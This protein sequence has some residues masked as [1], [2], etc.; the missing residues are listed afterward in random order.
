MMRLFGILLLVIAAGVTVGVLP[1]APSW[2][3]VAG[4][5]GLTLVAVAVATLARVPPA[6]GAEPAAPAPASQPGF[7][8]TLLMGWALLFGLTGLGVA[9]G[10]VTGSGPAAVGVQSGLAILLAI[11]FGTRGRKAMVAACLLVLPIALFNVGQG[12]EALRL[13]VG[14]A[15]H[16]ER[17]AAAAAKGPADVYHVA[18]ATPRVDLGGRFVTESATGPRAG[19]TSLT[20]VATAA[21]LLGPSWSA[22][23]PVPMWVVCEDATTEKGGVR[24]A[25][26]K[27]VY[28]RCAKRWSRQGDFASPASDVRSLY[29]RAVEATEKA[30]GL[31]SAASAPAVRWIASPRAAARPQL[32]TLAAIALEILLGWLLFVV[33]RGLRREP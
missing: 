8:P 11:V 31:Q 13:V 15:V 12:A 33:L 26:L 10:L 1:N 3:T 9:V 19:S 28:Q 2:G 23:Q 30:H 18:E 14:T 17:P 20:R 25:W 6:E 21:P 29:A 22:G 16:A 5:V 24:P 7:V 32:L 27:E 4:C